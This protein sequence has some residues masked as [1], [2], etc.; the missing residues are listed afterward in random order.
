MAIAAGLKRK[1]EE[2]SKVETELSS[3]HQTCQLVVKTFNNISRDSPASFK[4]YANLAS[5][6]LGW[7]LDLHLWAQAL[8]H[9]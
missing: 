8:Q 2:E 3:G 1:R 7:V 6:H 9:R 5:A 4:E